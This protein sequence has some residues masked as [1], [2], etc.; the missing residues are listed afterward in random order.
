MIGDDREMRDL[1]VNM[2]NTLGYRV[3]DVPEARSARAVLEIG[4]AFDLVLLDIVLPGGMNGPEFAEEMS[5]RGPDVK[6]IFMSG[7]PVEAAKHSRFPGPP[8]AL[9]NKPFLRSEL[10]KAL[11]D[12]LD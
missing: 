1:A 4:E 12:A 5:A 9:L 3:T 6:I 7:Y 11:R 10:A 2:L 8:R